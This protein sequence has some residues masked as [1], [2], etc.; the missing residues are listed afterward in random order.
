MLR[1]QRELSRNRA[2]FIADN[3]ASHPLGVGLGNVSVINYSFMDG[4]EK[5]SIHDFIYRDPGTP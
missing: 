1:Q 5:N 2:I 3:E 4:T